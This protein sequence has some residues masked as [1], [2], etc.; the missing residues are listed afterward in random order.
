MLRLFIH[1][2]FVFLMFACASGGPGPR[3]HA[4]RTD[5][6]PFALDAGVPLPRDAGSLPPASVDAGMSLPLRDA[7]SRPDAWVSPVTPTRETCDGLDQD[8]DGR[9][10]E[11]FLC[12]M[13]H[14]GEICVTSCGAAGFRVCAAPTCSWSE[15]CLPFDESCDTID[16]DC[17]GVVD[18]GC[19][20][21]E[22][23]LRIALSPSM[24]AL[25]PA[26][27]RIRLWLSSSPKESVRGA[28]LERSVPESH[29]PWSSITLWCDE[30]RPEWHI[31]DATDRTALGSGSFD[32]LSLDGVDLRPSTSFC[33]DPE[34]PGTGFRPIIMWDAIR[35]GS[36]PP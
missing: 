18:E 32:E 26:G 33:E 29:G 31:W 22:H 5:A 6:G 25:C 12:P 36:C 17:D 3:S 7:G 13:G 30:R 21:E 14:V 27:W 11:D 8:L 35:R 23:R 1:I 10:D 15:A 19:A 2:A 24:R 34:S 28:A 4:R 20:P 9:I 16:N